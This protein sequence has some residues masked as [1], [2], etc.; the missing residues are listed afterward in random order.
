MEYI[1]LLKS[2]PLFSRMDESSL[3]E[4]AQALAERKFR[5]NTWIIF[6]GEEANAYGWRF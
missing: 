4:L 1:E 5:K 3:K 6:E 2:I